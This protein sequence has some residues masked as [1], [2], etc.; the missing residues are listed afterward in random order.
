MTGL[1]PVINADGLVAPGASFTLTASP[2]TA[3]DFFVSLTVNGATQDGNTFAVANIDKHL[4]VLAVFGKIVADIAEFIQALQNPNCDVVSL[5]PNGVI[6]LSSR[7]T[8]TRN[9]II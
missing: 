6:T 3:N 1:S 5:P 9:L 7:A 8:I 2:A 4:E